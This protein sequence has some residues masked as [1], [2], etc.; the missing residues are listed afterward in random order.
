[1]YQRA[2]IE[3]IWDKE[4]SM[5][6]TQHPLN[7]N[8]SSILSLLDSLKPKVIWINARTNVATELATEENK[9]KEGIP[10]EKL[11]STKRIS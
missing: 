3:E 10:P 2:F 5:N 11:V 4:E 7:K 1:M 6:Q 9:K 8:E